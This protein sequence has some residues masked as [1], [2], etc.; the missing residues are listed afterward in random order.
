MRTSACR[1][2]SDRQHHDSAAAC[3]YGRYL[4]ATH[5][6]CRTLVDNLQL[7]ANYERDCTAAGSLPVS[8]DN[9]QVGLN[10]SKHPLKNNPAP[11]PGALARDVHTAKASA[12]WVRPKFVHLPREKPFTAASF[13]LPA[14]YAIACTLC[15]TVR[16]RM[17][18]QRGPDD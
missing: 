15:E 13:V 1:A 7:Y 8:S 5:L 18:D 2:P 9:Q 17:Q 3:D 16:C 11:R 4:R 14:Q 6:A 10:S 12:T